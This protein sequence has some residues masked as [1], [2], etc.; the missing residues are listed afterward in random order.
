LKLE[1]FC[2]LGLLRFPE[3]LEPSIALLPDA[4]KAEAAKILADLK[5]LPRAE[6]L[7]RWAQLREDESFVMRQ[8]ILKQAGFYL[9][10][11]P[12]ALQPWCA[13]WWADQHG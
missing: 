12:P 1:V 8:E 10:E 2:Y 9:D 6:L 11:L 3:Q 13:S 4:E 7:R 5:S